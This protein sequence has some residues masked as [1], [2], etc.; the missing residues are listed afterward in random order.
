MRVLQRGVTL[1]E[2]MVVLVIAG[3]VLAIAAPT[4]DWEHYQ[5]ESSMEGVGLTLLAVERQAITQQHDVIVMCDQARNEL[6]IHDDANN[7]GV[8]DAGERLRAM[9][10]G[11]HIV[12][13]RGSAPAMASI[14][15]GPIGFTVTEEGYPAMVFHRD[16]SA[17]ES[18][19]FYLTSTR[20]TTSSVY[21]QDARAIYV[22]VATGRASWYRYSTTSG[23]QRAF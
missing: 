7:N 8:V 19:G 11:E 16:G 1:V 21:T 12:F 23:W 6:W 14:G 5:I 20:A 17:S 2:M 15:S 22:D 18:Q 13:G 4:I 9:P 3:L 10:L